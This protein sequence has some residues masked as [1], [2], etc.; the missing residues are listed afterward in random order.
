MREGFQT[1]DHTGDLGLEVWAETPERLFELAAEAVLAQVAEA[2]RGG[3]SQRGARAGRRRSCRPLRPL[4][5]H[6]PARSGG[7]TRDLDPCNGPRSDREH[8]FRNAG[9]PAPRS[10]PPHPASRGEGRLT[11][12]FGADPP[13][14]RVPLSVRRGPLDP[15]LR[16]RSSS[17]A[18]DLDNTGR[19]R[20]VDRAAGF[21]I[22]RTAAAA[23][24]RCLLLKSPVLSYH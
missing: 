13:R 17:A 22:A 11:P 24:N 20:G 16:G 10:R 15:A 5:Q 2:F 19:A 4:A 21:R 18:S 1:F 7:P 8:A 3:R 12:R 23:P 6:G 14:L 9:R